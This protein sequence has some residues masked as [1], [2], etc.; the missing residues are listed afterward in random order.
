MSDSKR[1]KLRLLETHA[2][3][4][5]GQRGLLLA[6]PEGLFDGQVF[7]PEG[8]LPVVVQ[9]C[10]D[11]SFAEIAAELAEQYQQELEPEFVE[12]I[13]AE[14]RDKLCL[15]GPE[16]EA[17]RAKR[18]AEY[19]SSPA[20]PATNAGSAGYPEGAEA[21]ASRL[22]EILAELPATRDLS[23][24]V[25]PHIDL[26]R[27]EEG[28]RAAY[29]A[30]A[31]SRKLEVYVVVGTGHR[32]SESVLV[33][34]AKAYATPL[35]VVPVAEPIV[36]SAAD[37]LGAEVWDEEIRHLTE[38]SVE[39][40]V[41]F[42]RYLHGSA[43]LRIAPFLTGHCPDAPKSTELGRALDAIAETIRDIGVER[44]GLI[45]GADLAHIGPFFGD[46]APVSDEQLRLLRE[47]DL[48]S[49]E[50]YAKGDFDGFFADVEQNDNPRRICG[51]LPMYCV[52]KLRERLGLSLKSELLHYGQALAPD[53]S[54][55]VSFASLAFWE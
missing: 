11:K 52:G 50:L 7:V 9:F 8:L 2:H 16:V 19:R 22:G 42:L 12:R 39:F 40:Q 20:R 4:E 28:Y 48:R 53:R 3:E 43:E 34:T 51:T 24:L 37:A 38:H 29:G 5:D 33:P 44:V 14:L 45:A 6:D 31:A 1:P 55:M 13:A 21:C 32:G 54:Q 26:L 36:N 23:A 10:G 17:L 46:L 18:L 41:L 30:L 35:G 47:A 15:E 49:L 25:A 27:G